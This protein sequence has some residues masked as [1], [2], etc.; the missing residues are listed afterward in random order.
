MCTTWSHYLNDHLLL[1]FGECCSPAVLQS[2]SKPRC[3]ICILARQDPETPNLL[4][5]MRA[6]VL[7]VAIVEL[8]GHF[9]CALSDTARSTS[10]H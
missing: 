4:Q 2:H 9:Y 3:A 6:E 8:S 10:Q 1:L 7:V 5:E